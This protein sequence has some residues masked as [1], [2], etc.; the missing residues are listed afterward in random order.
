MGWG[1]IWLLL[2][3]KIP[4]VALCWLVWWAIK[5]EPEPEEAAPGDGGQRIRP[6]YRHPRKPLPRAPRRGPHGGQALPA[7]ARMRR[8]SARARSTTP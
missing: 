2:I 4:L 5:Q 1:L 7:P 3:L 6:P 8:V